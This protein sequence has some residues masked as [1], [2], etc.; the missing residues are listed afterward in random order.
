MPL[1]PRAHPRQPGPRHHTHGNRFRVSGG[2]CAS[3]LKV[4]GRAPLTAY[5]R[6]MFG[7][8]WVDVDNN[9]CDTRNDVLR[10]DLESI[11]T[12][13]ACVVQSGRLIDPYT[14][15]TIRFVEGGDS[16]V[17]IDHV[18]AL[19]NAWRPVPLPGA[20]TNASHS[21]TTR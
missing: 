15:T 8:P 1:S 17:D 16:E 10:R 18:V 21:P 20:G 13:D 11:H 4:K 5:S 9:G 19:G 14:R 3:V 2:D 12:Y 7:T 6:E